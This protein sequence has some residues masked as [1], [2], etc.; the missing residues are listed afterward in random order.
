MPIFLV[1]LFASYGVFINFAI[2][3]IKQQIRNYVISTNK[4]RRKHRK[5]FK[6]VQK[7]V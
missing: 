2:R 7:E 1:Q 6:E 3:F 5:G 4:R